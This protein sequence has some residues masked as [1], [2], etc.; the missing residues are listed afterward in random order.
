MEVRQTDGFTVRF[1]EHEIGC[2]VAYLK[3]LF[4]GQAVFSFESV[5]F[6]RRPKNQAM[7]E[8]V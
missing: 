7:R 5:P 8:D 3:M 1:R 6:S 2:L 4:V